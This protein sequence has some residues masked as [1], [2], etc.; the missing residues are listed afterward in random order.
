MCSQSKELL[1]KHILLWNFK[2]NV[3]FSYFS[4]ATTME[5]RRS[6]GRWNK[7][8][9]RP[10]W[11]YFSWKS[12]HKNEGSVATKL[13]RELF[14]SLVWYLIL[15]KPQRSRCSLSKSL[16]VRV[17]CFQN[18]LPRQHKAWR[19]INFFLVL[20]EVLL[21]TPAPVNELG[22]RL[23]G[24]RWAGM[25]CVS[26]EQL[27]SFSK[28]R[29]SRRPAWREWPLHSF[30]SQHSKKC[31]GIVWVQH[32]LW[33]DEFMPGKALFTSIDVYVYS[34]ASRSVSRHTWIGS[35]RHSLK[36]EWC[37]KGAHV[38]EMCFMTFM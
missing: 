16:G 5:L 30:N 4:F 11:K 3:V 25:V 7:L 18:N 15:W 9:Q 20:V 29:G 14:V 21:A 33:K 28:T 26:A 19:N 2:I 8:G 23:F 27:P 36:V 10:R 13:E 12:V 1:F 37:F 35:Q 17:S 34:P 24:S 32:G 31:P 6:V 22:L 38:L